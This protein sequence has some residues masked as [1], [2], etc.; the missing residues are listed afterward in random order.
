[1]LLSMTSSLHDWKKTC[2][3]SI[4]AAQNEINIEITGVEMWQT[5]TICH[6]V[7]KPMH[8]SHM[9]SLRC[10]VI[11][12]DIWYWYYNI[13][14]SRGEMIWFPTVLSILTHVPCVIEKTHIRARNDLTL[15][16]LLLLVWDS[17]SDLVSSDEPPLSL[18][19]E[20]TSAGLELLCEKG[21]G[22]VSPTVLK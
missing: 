12:H 8:A 18:R 2:Y 15:R 11:N 9:I 19:W 5:N 21:G 10:Y 20:T 22:P 1:M 13:V 6:T 7:T 16:N 3:I 14:R 17:L 4:D